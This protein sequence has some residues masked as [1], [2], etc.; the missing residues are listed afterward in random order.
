MPGKGS[1]S[2]QPVS[3][4]AQA[5]LFRKSIIDVGG[6]LGFASPFPS[7]T[8]DRHLLPSHINDKG[9]SWLLISPQ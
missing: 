7:E 2:S 3:Q 1:I 5:S 4:A 8:K 9:L 6:G